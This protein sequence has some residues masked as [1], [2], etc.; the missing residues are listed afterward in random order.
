[1]YASSIIILCLGTASSKQSP[2]INIEPPSYA[3]DAI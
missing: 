2:K 1:M 3:I